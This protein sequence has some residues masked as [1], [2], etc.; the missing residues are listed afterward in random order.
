MPTVTRNTTLPEIRAWLASGGYNG[1]ACSIRLAFRTPA[2]ILIAPLTGAGG[3]GGGLFAASFL[4][5]SDFCIHS[6]A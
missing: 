2:P 6:S 4:I 3:E 1:S 5:S